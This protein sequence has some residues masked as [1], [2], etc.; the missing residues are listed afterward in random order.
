MTF[1][2]TLAHIAFKGEYYEYGAPRSSPRKRR[3]TAGIKQASLLFSGPWYTLVDRIS[4]ESL[5]LEVNFQT[6][7]CSV[8][9]TN[10]FNQQIEDHI[11]AFD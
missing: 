1:A 4:P 7:K 11:Y 8:E 10:I 9:F 3:A 5:L 6:V 2:T